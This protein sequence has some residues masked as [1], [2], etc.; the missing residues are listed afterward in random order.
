MANQFS[1]IETL[2]G[3][4]RF[5][6]VLS[7]TGTNRFAGVTAN[8]TPQTTQQSGGGIFGGTVGA[9]GKVLL[10]PQAATTA[11][12][13]KGLEKLGILEP[14]TKGLGV[15]EA[16]SKST[17]NTELLRRIG[18]EKNTTGIAALL[19]GN[20]RPTTSV[21]GNFV[22][23]LPVTATGL[24]ADIFLDP[25][26]YLG[27]A[28][29]VKRATTG[30]GKAVQAGTHVLADKVPAIQQMGDALGR[31]FLTRYGQ[32]PEFQALD[33]QRKISEGLEAERV[34]RLVAPVIDKPALIQQ[35]ITEVIKGANPTDA[36]LRE[37]AKPIRD[38]L[39]RVGEAISKLNPKLLSEETFAANKGTYFPRLYSDYEFP[40]DEEGLIKN[41]FSGRPASVPREPFKGRTL[42]EIESVAKGTRIE[43]AGYPA[44][45]RM[46]QLS[47]TEQRQQFFKN[48]ATLASTEAKPGWIQLSSDKAL[49]DLAG[50]FLPAG[51]YRAIAEVRKTQSEMER[52]YGAALSQW[53][54][55]KTAYNPATISRNNMTNFFILNPLGGVGPH[56]LDI[57]AKAVNEYMS[58]GPLYQAARKNGLEIS[59]Q[60]AA[61]LTTKARTLYQEENKAISKFFGS[62]KSFNEKVKN[63]YGSQDKFFKL[64]NFIKGVS[65]DGLT[66]YEAMRRANFYLIDYSEVPEFVK[67]ARQSP[68]GVPFISFA[69]GVSK[70][71]AKTLLESPE[72]L[73][74]YYKVLRAVQDMN[75]LGETPAE[76]QREQG[77]LPDWISNGTFLRLPVKDQYARSQYVDLQ[78]IL[79]FNILETKSITPN[80]PVLNT[81]ASLLT[82]VDPFTDREITEPTDTTEEKVQKYVTNI[83]SQIV[84]SWTPFIGTSFGK[85]VDALKHRPDRNGFVRSYLQTFLDVIGGI[86]ITP[87]D[88]T[89]EA[90]KRAG[91]RKREINLLQT[92][93]RSIL[94]DKSL[95]PEERQ[96]EA[97]EIREKIQATV[98]R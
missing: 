39:D 70:P 91:E 58:K 22:R 88:Q 8:S 97:Q 36:Q 95:F 96:R 69:Y 56:R 27:G 24:A 53:K 59:T 78:Y 44:L 81:I 76:L 31:L 74:A 66:P 28:G 2:P 84:P 51:E 3:V 16:V 83:I 19:T 89:V 7:S 60:Q 17:S 5:T 42:T 55:F 35:R 52:L 41:M 75:P 65:E 40:V 49:G 38:E 85:A 47:V 4:N 79:P 13:N 64:A 57:Y 67:W 61:E 92:K 72:K 86:K 37:L 77:V 80:N 18:K 34:G 1:E 54:T 20:Y 12:I 43:E 82:N 9:L 71:L 68:V 14:K 10:A 50:K 29:L 90:Q 62:F 87:I 63:F 30:I 93:L 46:T 32:R 23:E 94:L 98:S 73:G 21:F 33:I 48:A 11:L 15:K 26:T 45:K 6:D 25:L